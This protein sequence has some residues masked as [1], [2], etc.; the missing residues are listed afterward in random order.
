MELQSLGW[1]DPPEKETATH[2]SIRAW[3]NP[4]GQRSLAGY[5]PYGC[6]EMDMTEATQHAK[7][8]EDAGGGGRLV[9]EDYQGKHSKQW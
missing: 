3:E 5:S 2:S 4:H 7:T 8:K 6:K 1:E 9:W